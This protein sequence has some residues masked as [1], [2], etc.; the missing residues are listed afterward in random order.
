MKI[1]R[2]LQVVCVFLIACVIISLNNLI[3]ISPKDDAYLFEPELRWFN[4]FEGYALLID[5]NLE[6]SSPYSVFVSDNR[7]NPKLDYGVYYWKVRSRGRESE[8]RRFTVVPLVEMERY[9]EMV[10]NSGN[11][12]L[13]L[14]F[15]NDGVITGAIVADVNED[16]NVSGYELVVGRQG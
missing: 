13:N 7:Y 5:D 15:F 11:V 6:F 10:R 9:R 14:E 4:N 2:A 8:T 16:V 1:E 3:L 12:R